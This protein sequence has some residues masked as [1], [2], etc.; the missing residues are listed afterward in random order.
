[1]HKLDAMIVKSI[2]PVFISLCLVWRVVVSGILIAKRWHNEVHL[3]IVT[4]DVAKH[5]SVIFLGRLIDR[6]MSHAR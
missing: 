1:M 5:V 2:D 3:L 4:M 6:G